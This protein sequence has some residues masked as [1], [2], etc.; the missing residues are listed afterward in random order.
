MKVAI[1]GSRDYPRLDQ[2][3]RYVKLLPEG[4]VVVSGGALGVDSCA[5]EEALRHDLA[6]EEFLPEWDR[7]GRGAGFI[8]NADI[9]DA[10]DLVVAFWDGKSRGTKNTIDLVRK[11]SKPF[12][13]VFP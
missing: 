10:A 11:A 6:T 8:R 4:T 3:R 9:V 7:L 2:V 13:V 12:V 1:V 5:A